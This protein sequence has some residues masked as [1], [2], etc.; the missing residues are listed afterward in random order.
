MSGTSLCGRMLACHCTRKAHC[1]RKSMDLT[2][3]VQCTTR[4]LYQ[5]FESGRVDF[6]WMTDELGFGC[7]RNSLFYKLNECELYLSPSSNY[8]PYIIIIKK[9]LH[10]IK[11][12]PTPIIKKNIPYYQTVR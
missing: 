6:S 10:Q 11:N 3:S 4:N 8:I 9:I 12:W 5:D 2:R 7:L 1:L